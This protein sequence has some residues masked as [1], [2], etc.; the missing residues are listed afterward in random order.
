MRLEFSLFSGIFVALALSNALVPVLPAYTAGSAVQGAIY[1]AYFLG[2]FLTTLPGG[3]LSDRYGQI[4]MIRLGLIITLFSGI[5]LSSSLAT[6][7]VI[8]L[9]FGEGVG[10]GIL[11][12]ASMSH[13]NSLPDH[14][15]DERIPHRN[16]ECRSCHRACPL[17]L[18]RGL[19]PPA[20]GRNNPVHST[21]I[22]PR[23]RNPD[24]TQTKDKCSGKTGQGPA[25][26]L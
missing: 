7:P 14:Q 6:Y 3:L 18:A 12:A 21:L 10:A 11:I 4:P 16:P 8:L 19:S 25:A 15:T 2:A 5:L 24:R 22:P 26:S 17:R 20:H 13:V 1:S 9:R 23:R